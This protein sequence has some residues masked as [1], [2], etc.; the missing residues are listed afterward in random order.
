MELR[1][2]QKG[3]ELVWDNDKL[4]EEYGRIERAKRLSIGLVRRLTGQPV[5]P[6]LDDDPRAS[7]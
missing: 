1:K 2:S 7:P 5:P 4:F 3:A 6:H